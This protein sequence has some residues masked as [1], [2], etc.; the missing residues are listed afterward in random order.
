LLSAAVSVYWGVGG[1][2]LLNTV[3]GSFARLGRNPTTSTIVAVWA[4]AT[5]KLAAALLPL[6]ALR[7]PDRGSR[8][9]RLLAW[10][11]AGI[12]SIYGAVLT[13]V[14]LLVQADVI[15][16]PANA[17]RRALTWHAYVWDP[18]F[19]VWG[20]VILTALLRSRTRT[21]GARPWRSRE[22]AQPERAARPIL[23]LACD[24]K[25]PNVVQNGGSH[26]AELLLPPDDAEAVRLEQRGDR[27]PRPP[28]PL[29]RY[30]KPV[31]AEI[32]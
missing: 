8:S 30:F 10:A 2:W 25:Q 4:A 27:K 20:L 16:S 32:W 12:L 5:L 28:L 23:F 7:N 6:L 22:G 17:D 1:T 9:A 29:P 18:W 21:L 13:S 15:D 19:L 24:R 3:G 31:R 11:A 14:G 26:N